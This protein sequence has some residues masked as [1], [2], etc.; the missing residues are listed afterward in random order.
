MTKNKELTLIAGICTITAFSLLVYRVHITKI[1]NHLT[2]LWIFLVLIAQ[3]LLYFF[4]RINHIFGIYVPSVIM[5]SGI[6]YIL[7]VKITYTDSNRIEDE[8]KEKDIL[9][10]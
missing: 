6:L 7:Y 3:L 4:G 5:F 10:E 9:K 8:L 2:Y 1:T